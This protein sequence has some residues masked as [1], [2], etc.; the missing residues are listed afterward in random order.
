M[1]GQKGQPI[2]A[3]EPETN[4]KP[5]SEAEFEKI[6]NDIRIRQ[7]PAKKSPNGKVI[8]EARFPFISDHSM[9]IYLEKIRSLV[10]VV[11]MDRARKK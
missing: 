3:I 2:D 1:F 5:L 7:T 10:G 11:D 4:L 8:Y 9:D 6:K